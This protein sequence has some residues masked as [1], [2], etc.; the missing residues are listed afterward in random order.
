MKLAPDARIGPYR[1]V[2]LIGAGEMGEVYR[3]HDARL[4]RDVAIKVLPDRIAENADM[5]ARF[6]REVRAIAALSHP[7]VLSIYDVGRE[8]GLI[9][10]V[11]ELVQ[12]VTLRERM[13]ATPLAHTTVADIARQIARG[14]LA[15]HAKQIVHRDLK[16]EN[17]LISD[18]GEVK[19]LDFGLAKAD[20]LGTASSEQA[21]LFAT[22]PGLIMGTLAYMSPEQ[23]RGDVV[24]HRTDIFSFGAMI[25]EMLA[26]H[27]PFI[28]PTAAETIAE[29]LSPGGADPA[30]LASMPSVLGRV[31]A[32][33]LAKPVAERTSSFADVLAALDS[34]GRLEPGTRVSAAGP[35]PAV[36]TRSIA[37][38]PFADMTPAKDQDYFCEG[39]ADEIIT[40]LA[41]V[42]GLR[43][44]ARTSAFRF[45][46]RT[47][48]VRDIARA[49]GVDTLLE[50]SVRVAGP[51]I[52]VT[53]QLVN[54][55]DG[56]QLWTER[57]DRDTAD[58]FAVQDEI[59]DTVRRM[60]SD[61]IQQSFR[62]ADHTPRPATMDAY[63]AYL[64]G[65]HHWSRRTATGLERSVECFREALTIDGRYAPAWAG[66]ADAYVTQAIYG[67]RPPIDVMPMAREAATKALATSPRLAGAHAALGCV[68]SLFDW[69]WADA[70]RAFQ[71]ALEIDPNLAIAWQWRA[72]HVLLPQGHFDR[73]ADALARAQAL[74]PVSPAIGASLGLRSLFANQLD[75]AFEELGHALELDPDVPVLHFFNGLALAEAG[76]LDEAGQAFDSALRLGASHAEIVA[77]RG[78]TLARAGDREGADAAL[79]DLEGIAA[80]RYVSP[81]T[82]AQVHACLGDAT[83]TIDL[84]ERAV[85]VR[86][87]DLVWLN[88]R[89]AF[90]SLHGD[91]RFRAIVRRL[92]LA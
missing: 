3:A 24:D 59:A 60:L 58:V 17:M 68:L 61:T 70:D 65:R 33:C 26:G 28:R 49:L 56:Y 9:Y 90:R 14:M 54:A 10:A 46:G 76:R 53:A 13:S 88:V 35:A 12:G 34:T 57:F 67:V 8:D 32:G 83:R 2:R 85:D 38:L 39:M 22:R 71:Q 73:A 47:D 74:D 27:P 92:G 64:K 48:D 42:P 4:G 77:S 78:Y 75:R 43:V 1:V 82:I 79:R 45:K 63:T 51:R 87:A 86:A 50:G 44:V 6:E 25:Y 5:V 84:L 80:V 15:A 55:T 30:E 11:M 66:L 23:V 20:P 29:L 69:A 19:I 91:E 52:R 72:M 81:A 7:N 41:K 62:T 40:A 37:V 31:V 16:P 89:P 36:V 18:A 21:T